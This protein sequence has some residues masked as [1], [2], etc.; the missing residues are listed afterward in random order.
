MIES[1]R[2][3]FHFGKWSIHWYSIFSV[4]GILMVIIFVLLNAKKYKL[5]IR[6]L[7]SIFVITIVGGYIGARIL[8]TIGTLNKPD[9][10]VHNIIEFLSIWKGGIGIEGAGFAALAFFFI[11]WIIFARK[12]T[13]FYLG[14]KYLD[15][16]MCNV[17]IGQVFGRWGNFFNQ[18][19]LG[20]KV[21]SNNWIF[22]I[23]PKFIKHH[24][25]LLTDKS[26]S[27]R[28]PLFIVESFFC[29]IF[30]VFVCY[31]KN[32]KSKLNI[33]NVLND[34]KYLKWH[35]QESKKVVKKDEYMINW[36]KPVHK[37]LY[38]NGT[39]YKITEMQSH[40]VNTYSLNYGSVALLWLIF[41]GALRT[42][43][44]YFRDQQD[45][46]TLGKLYL[47]VF[48]SCVYFV[49]G[50]ILFCLNQDIIKSKK[51]NAFKEWCFNYP[52]YI[53]KIT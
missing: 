45:I 37:Y 6:Y 28:F 10:K 14:L 23:L 33:M 51:F 41:Y 5:P 38:V 35:R 24:C 9:E 42:V 25:Y 48:I 36:Q 34:K 22:K 43:L 46:L 26:H 7:E 47:S 11:Y 21:S 19:I 32:R 31:L 50:F 40:K 18:E 3:A 52:N 29:F 44:E 4:I 15:I 8:F 13:Q 53:S 20:P 39:K 16:I 12:K 27:L 30:W 49:S 1:F 17:F 2:I